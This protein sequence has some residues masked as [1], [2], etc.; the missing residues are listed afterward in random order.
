MAA[1]RRG[2]SVADSL[3]VA[4]YLA[5]SLPSYGVTHVFELIGGMI[6]TLIDELQHQPELSVISMHHEQGAGFAAEGFA[7][8][9]GR[10]SVA[11][12]TSGPGATNL[13]TAIGSCYFDSTPV[14]FITGQVNRSEIHTPGRGRQLGFQETDIVSMALPVTKGARQVSQARDFPDVLDWAF[15]LATSG[16]P[17]PVLIDVPMDVQ[18]EAV[19]EA[20]PVRA[21]R[22]P[23][24]DSANTLERYEFLVRLA[25]A[26]QRSQRPLIL[27]GGG[28]RRA[29]AVAAFRDLVEHLQVPV[30]TS[31][32][33]LDTISR[34]STLR[35]GLIGSYGNRWSNWAIGKSDLLLVLGSRLDIRQ[36]GADIV[37]FTGSR[38][39]FH[40]D[41]D[42]GELNGRVPG[43]TVLRDDLNDFLLSD[44]LMALLPTIPRPRFADEIAH[45]RSHWPDIAE[46]IPAI[47]VNPNI[48][49]H[50]ICKSWPE[51]SAI[52][53]D[54]GQHQMWAAQS[55]ELEGDQLFITSGGMGSMGF[56]LP[57]A[58]GAAL[59]RPDQ[60]VALI[61]GDGGFQCNIQELQTVVRLNLPIRIVVFNNQGHGMVRQFQESYFDKRYHSTR[62]GY[63]APAFVE[64]A[65]AYGLRA[66]AANSE[67]A[68]SAVLARVCEAPMRPVL[69]EVSIDPD[70]NAYPK[71][72]YGDSFGSMEPNVT[73]SQ[74]EG[75]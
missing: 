66:L 44:N 75:T 73:S 20:P 52:V 69:I 47:G 54:V 4:R 48:A 41:I 65:R 53:T 68:L 16:R 2:G 30:V 56:G 74:M 1:E 72:A 70:L 29:N 28:V 64:V 67:E 42:S 39:I 6:A 15:S 26:L 49:V 58:I 34:D 33:G 21:R 7:R 38:E 36:T 13:L 11:L 32:M 9:A 27:A 60:P 24:R 45:A 61:A 40:V 14:V 37:G 51:L 57:A 59:A 71:M 12:A 8:S 23:Q 31:L 5:Q 46:N 3:S 35:V 19:P 55:A 10:P 18:R 62:W 50:A 25:G 17:G 63:S 43:C 22:L